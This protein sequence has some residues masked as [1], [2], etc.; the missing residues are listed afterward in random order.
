MSI[1]I[2][3]EIV[4]RI[5]KGTLVFTPQLDTFQLQAHS[6]D[7]R[8]GYTFLVY[9]T[10]RLTDNG[11]TAVYLDYGESKDHFDVIE[12]EEGQYFDI[13]P[14]E[15]VVVS[16]LER[17]KLSK[18]I[19]AVLYPRSSVNR[20]GLSVDLSGVI[21]AGYEGN[22]II[23]LRNNTESQIVRIYP[24]ERF[25]QIVFHTLNAPVKPRKSRYAKKDI[26]VGVLNEDEVREQKFIRNGKI[27]NLKERYRLKSN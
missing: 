9:K 19:M 23:P 1:L 27:K 2:K 17:I 13:L 18:D 24:G 7:L 16:T 10:W 20:K 22:L 21:D 25:C 26:V 5:K 8:L 12:L 4:E 15:Y 14:H 11:R 3:D 6:I